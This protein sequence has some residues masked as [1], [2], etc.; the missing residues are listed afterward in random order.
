MKKQRGHEQRITYTGASMLPTF[1]EGDALNI[2]ACTAE[3]LRPGDVVVFKSLKKNR[4]IVHRVFCK[5]K[6]MIL[7]RGDNNSD[8]DI[9]P[10]QYEQILGKVISARRL[11]DDIPIQQGLR[12]QYRSSV[13]RILKSANHGVSFLLHHPYHFLANLNWL[14][15]ISWFRSRIRIISYKRQAGEE[16]QMLFGSRVIGYRRAG[17]TDWQIKKPFRLLVGTNIIV[18]ET[19]DKSRSVKKAFSSS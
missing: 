10:L 7:T 14:S 4:L 3:E 11:G 9:E 13:L 8:V 1:Q 5:E 19:I 18:K 17:K 16:L 6:K 15:R 2:A 12:G